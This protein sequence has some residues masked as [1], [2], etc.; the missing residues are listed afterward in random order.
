MSCKPCMS[1]DS[2]CIAIMQGLQHL[3]GIDLDPAA[4]VIAADKLQQ[5]AND[6]LA[7]HP[8]QGNFG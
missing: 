4:H 3:V 1:D 2:F 7:I 6:G 8:L 5:F